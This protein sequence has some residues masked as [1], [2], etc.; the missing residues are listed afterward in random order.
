MILM[1]SRNARPQDFS[2]I[3]GLIGMGRVDTKPWIT[4]RAPFELAVENSPLWT[5][6]E[7]S[8]IKA[9]IGF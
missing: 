4:H 7:T 9:I 8:V 5:K 1:G 6:S 3:I 2:P